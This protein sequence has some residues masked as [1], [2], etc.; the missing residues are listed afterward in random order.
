MAKI[1]QRA[2]ERIVGKKDNGLEE[3]LKIEFRK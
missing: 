1:V 2:V 3:Y